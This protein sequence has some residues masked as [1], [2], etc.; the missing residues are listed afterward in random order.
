M[1]NSYTE[2]ANWFGDSNVWEGHNIDT[3]KQLLSELVTKN[4][5]MVY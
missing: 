2:K 5:I 4:N 3:E 1:V